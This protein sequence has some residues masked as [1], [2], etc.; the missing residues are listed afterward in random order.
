MITLDNIR[1]L[2]VDPG[3]KVAAYAYGIGN[4]LEELTVLLI[5]KEA[6][7]FANPPANDSADPWHRCYTLGLRITTIIYNREVD[8]VGVELPTGD[9]DNPHTDRVISGAFAAVYFAARHAGARAVI[10]RPSAV[11]ATGFSKKHLRDATLLAR[12]HLHEGLVTE[13]EADALGV[14]QATLAVMTEEHRRE[15]G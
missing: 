3:S 5:A 7:A 1:I 2:G 4:K 12:E 11:K 8:V 6:R 15:H 9:H 13:D 14:W 10:V